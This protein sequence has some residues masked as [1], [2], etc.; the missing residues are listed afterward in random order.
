MLATR[1][2]LAVVIPAVGKADMPSLSLIFVQEPNSHHEWSKRLNVLAAHMDDN[3]FEAVKQLLRRLFHERGYR[4]TI[5]SAFPKIDFDRRVGDRAIGLKFEV[6]GFHGF[7]IGM[8][9]AITGITNE[10]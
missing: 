8:F 1:Y 6:S 2:E 4:A 5:L 3:H 10:P 7:Q 9:K